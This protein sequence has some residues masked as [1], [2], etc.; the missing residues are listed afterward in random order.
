MTKDLKVMDATAIVF[1]RDNQ[2]PIVVFD[3]SA[4][5]CRM[6]PQ[7]RVGRHDGARRTPPYL[8]AARRGSG[9][10]RSATHVIGDA[11]AVTEETLLDAIDKMEKAV[12]HTQDQF[13]TVRTGRATP[14]LVEKLLVEYYGSPVPLQ[15]PAA[16]QAPEARQLIVK[17]HDPL[18][19]CHRAGHPRQRPG[20]QPE[21][22]RRRDP[23]GLPHAHRGAPPR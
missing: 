23:A 20:C 15:Q 13:T 17:P 8:I 22:R 3:M 6:H 11:G 5:V 14:A 12:A 10:V 21:Q 4:P 7:W 9:D 16:F 18:P 1:C 2:I 19:R